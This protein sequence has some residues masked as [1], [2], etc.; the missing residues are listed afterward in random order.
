M[1]YRIAVPDMFTF[2]YLFPAVREIERKK[3]FMPE[4]LRDLLAWKLSKR[5][6][7]TGN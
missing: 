3:Y 2:G 6:Y 4:F 5:D 7:S 1:E